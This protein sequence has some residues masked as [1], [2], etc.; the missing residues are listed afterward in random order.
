MS[1]RRSLRLGVLLVL[2][3]SL[4]VLPGC[5]DDATGPDLSGDLAT[6]VE[7]NPGETLGLSITYY[8]ADGI[9]A[10]A[11]NA[12]I[13]DD[14]SLEQDLEDGHDGVQVHVSVVEGVDLTVRL[15]ADGDVVAESSSPD[16]IS[17]GTAIYLVEAGDVQEISL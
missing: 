11:T 6:V 16:Q 5:G 14:G 17:N 10:T 1:A 12:T 3:V 13:P 2:V 4:G 7:G 9:D 15:T 8:D